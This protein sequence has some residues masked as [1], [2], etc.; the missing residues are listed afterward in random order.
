MQY[1]G[2]APIR[3]FAMNEKGRDLIVGDIHGCFRKLQVALDE[4][5]FDQER[6][7]L[8]GVGDLVDR[9]PD[10]HLAM[11]WLDRP[12][13][14]AVRG[15][16]EQMAIDFVRYG[17]TDRAIYA[18]NGGAWNIANTP[19]ERQRFADAFDTLPVAM[20]LETADGLVG[21]V[22]ADCPGHDWAH[23]AEALNDPGS[24][25]AS[26]EQ[27]CMWSRD[28]I[29]R[30]QPEI[31]DGVR[32][33]VVGHTPLKQPTALGNVLYIDTGAVFGGVFTI[34]DAATLQPAEM[35]LRVAA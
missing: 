33:V 19:A 35:R 16:H 14:H 31:I 11:E 24:M 32:A 4:L 34:L 13:F 10:S 17:G 8:F 21:V 1:A 22:H 7:R 26:A 23:V 3:R 12:W 27:L 15:N 5:G 29:N 6:D 18:H 25:G 9:G 28:R 30:G 2:Y 20:E